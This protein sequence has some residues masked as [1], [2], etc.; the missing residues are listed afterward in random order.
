[1]SSVDSFRTR[2]SED[3]TPPANRMACWRRT[4]P[5]RLLSPGVSRG[6]GGEGVAAESGSC[7]AASSVR[8]ILPAP[9][10]PG[11]L[12][13]P[14]PTV[15]QSLAC[16]P[17]RDD[18]SGM[19]ATEAAA[20]VATIVAMFGSLTLMV[21]FVTNSPRRRGR[22]EIEKL[23]KLKELGLLDAYRGGSAT[24]EEIAE[25]KARLAEHEKAIA[26]LREERD[27]VRKRLEQGKE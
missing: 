22:A 18:T 17:N 14:E 13:A 11:Y 12:A 10:A 7:T 26:E 4:E 24:G 6:G 19:D 1:M 21:R 2:G 3:T 27:F 5:I 8:V 23:A 25:L 15:R 9:E 16:R 20:L